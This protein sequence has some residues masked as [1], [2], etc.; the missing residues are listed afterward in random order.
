MNICVVGLGNIGQSLYTHL[1][2]K[3]PHEVFGIDIDQERVHTLVKQGYEVGSD[4]QAL[5]GVDIWLLVPST[6]ANAENLFEALKA[7]NIEAGSLISI[8]STLPPGTM[9]RVRTHLEDRGFELGRNLNLIHVPHRIMFGVDKTVC[10]T[11][12]VM[13]AFTSA[14]LD[15]GRQFYQQLVPMLVETLDVRAA[16]LSKVIEN[17]KRYVDIAFAQEVYRYCS[18]AGIGFEELR[19][20]VNSKDN[21]SLPEVDWGIGGECLP[22]DIGFLS[23]VIASPLLSG[24]IQ[25]DQEFREEIVNQV[26][27]GKKVL[28][29]GVTYKTG[30]K[31]L[32]HSRGVNLVTALQEHGNHVY[33]EDPL[34]EAQELITAGFQPAVDMEYLQF[35]MVLD[36][37]AP[38]HGQSKPE[39]RS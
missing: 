38:L 21:V 28:V 7:M 12:R 5:S 8:E 17:A 39:K 14:C 25:A 27:S 34:L 11:P 20:A 9:Q 32:E 35:D 19:Q 24:A 1:R 13:G 36:R 4:Y 30:V 37:T 16:E 6:G 15:R 33:V 3:F 2:K 29:R 22:K 10:D 23:R 26:G 18:E 31:N